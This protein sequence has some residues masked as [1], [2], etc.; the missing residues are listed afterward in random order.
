MRSFTYF[1]LMKKACFFISIMLLPYYSLA[2]VSLKESTYDLTHWDLEID[3]DGSLI[4]SSTTS[5][6]TSSFPSLIIE[7]DIVKLELVPAIGGRVM[8]YIYKPNGTEQLYQNPVSAPYLVGFGIFYHDWLML[9]GGIFPTYPETPHGKYWFS[10]YNV[11]ILENTP[12]KV[13]VKMFLQDNTENPNRPQQFQDSNGITNMITEVVVTLEKGKYYFDYGVNLINT[14]AQ[15]ISY[16]YW[17]G[18][19]FAPGSDVNNT[20]SPSSST[21]VAPIETFRQDFNL[22][23]WVDDVERFEGDL[24]VFEN[25]RNLNRWENI[26]A[27][28]A[29]PVLID[30]QN[31]YGVINQDARMGLMRFH[32]NQSVTPGFRMWTFGDEVG[33]TADINDASVWQRPF[34]EFWAGVSADFGTNAILP[35]SSTRSWTEQYIPVVDMPGVTAMNEHFT[36]W[37]SETPT[38]LIAFVFRPTG[39]EAVI[40]VDL[41]GQVLESRKANPH[42]TQSQKFVFKK[43]SLPNLNANSVFSVR[44]SSNVEG[45]RIFAEI[46]L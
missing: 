5:M 32:K 26:G 23:N 41:D 40:E 35:A 4:S 36:V 15:D 9:P 18:I 43:S 34:I 7:N 14:Q 21:L 24:Q 6:V 46:E 28:I 8:S 10:P 39:V 38:E 1:S 42:L 20:F 31:F 17:T 27:I 11:Q 22:D 29:D 3:D 12:E 19:S 30:Q 33:R 13:S 25:L 45:D 37:L 44:A 16:K 2:A